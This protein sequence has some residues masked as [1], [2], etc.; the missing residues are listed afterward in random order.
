[1]ERQWFSGFVGYALQATVV[2]QGHSGW[3]AVLYQDVEL[4]S[5]TA[6]A[7]QLAH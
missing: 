7:D 6:V 4:D 3:I 1:M 2:F 5:E